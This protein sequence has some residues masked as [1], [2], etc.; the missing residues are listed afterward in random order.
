MAGDDARDG[1]EKDGPVGP[2]PR[3]LDRREMLLGLSTVPALG[4]FGYALHRQQ[5]FE[6][7]RK[8][9]ALAQ[10]AAAGDVAEV[11]VALLGAGA[12]GE[13][14]LN[15]MLRIPGLRF[16]AVC[17]IW[18]EYNQKRAVNTL[19]KYK[20]DVNGYEDYRE[21]LDKEKEIDAVVIA[22][23]DFWHATH[24]VECLKAGKH[25]YCE[26][27]MSNTLEGARSMV[28]A[29]RETKKLLQIGHQRRSNPRYLHALKLIDNDKILGRITHCNGQWNRSRLLENDCPKGEELDAATLKK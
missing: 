8:D 12:Q 18:K 7:Q 15:S 16:R 25:V 19:R 20:F 3:T 17:D 14:L 9:A 1:K 26:K 11:N 6:Q 28:Q 27:E 21:M 10:K 23:P 29:M 5:A 24:A 13:V 22:T 4:L 2:A